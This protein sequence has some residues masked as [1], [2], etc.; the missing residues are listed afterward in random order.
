MAD[1]KI[2]SERAIDMNELRKELEKIKQRDKELNFRAARTEEYLQHFAAIKEPE[3]LYK[4]IDGLKVPRL[5]EQHIA[6]I[7]DIMP[8]TVED[9]KSALKAYPVTL[10]NENLKKIT[11]IVN[12]HL[13]EK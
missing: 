4:E 9:I 6:K 1:V 11:D 2:L 7:M 12:K 5:R 13:E 10:T 3:K 8:R